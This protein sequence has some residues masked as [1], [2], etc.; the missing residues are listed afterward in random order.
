M[1]IPPSFGAGHPVQPGQQARLLLMDSRIIFVRYILLPELYS[2]QKDQNPQI[3]AKPLSSSVQSTIQL[4]R[5]QTISGIHQQLPRA[6]T[7]RAPTK[8]ALS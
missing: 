3:T 2:S 1:R 4:A 6:I 8:V 5:I 7:R